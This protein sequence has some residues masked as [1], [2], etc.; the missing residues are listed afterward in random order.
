MVL[1]SSIE[2]IHTYSRD[3]KKWDKKKLSSM[4]HG[5]S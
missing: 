2:K 5:Q 4:A 3:I 1:L